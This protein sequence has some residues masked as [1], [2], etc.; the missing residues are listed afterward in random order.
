MVEII[1][2]IENEKY[3][4]PFIS[5]L[6]ELKYISSFSKNGKKAKILEPLTDADWVR[7]GRPATQEELEKMIEE[8][9]KGPFYSLE[10]AKKLT[11]REFEE[12]KQKITM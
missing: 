9:E 6:N 12:W 8:A 3:V 4:K 7:P 10:D 11:L 1:V 5:L 2:T